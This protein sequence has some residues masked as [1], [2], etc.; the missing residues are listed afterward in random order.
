MIRSIFAEAGKYIPTKVLPALVGLLVIPVFTRIFDPEIY[1]QYGLAVSIISFGS[2]FTSGWLSNANM[3]FWVECK[4]ETARRNHL[5]TLIISTLVFSFLISL[6]IYGIM[7]HVSLLTSSFLIAAVVMLFFTPFI[8]VI[9]SY[10]RIQNKPFR[11][12]VFDQLFNSGKLLLGLLTVLVIFPG[13]GLKSVFWSGSLI[14]L[15]LLLLFLLSPEIRSGITLSAFSF[16]RFRHFF[17]YGFPLV[18]VLVS[19][20]ILT[21]SA[22]FIIPVLRPEAP[23]ELGWLTASQNIVDRTLTLLFQALMMAVLPNIFSAWE[24]TDKQT[25][26]SLITKLIGWFF[27]LFFPLAAGMSLLAEPVMD[28]MTGHQYIGGAVMIPYLALGAFLSNLVHYFTLPCSLHKKTL[29]MTRI[30]IVSAVVNLLLYLVFIPWLGFIGVGVALISTYIFMI[31]YSLY[32][33]R[34]FELIKLPWK[35]IFQTLTASGFMVLAVILL[36]SLSSHVWMIITGSILGGGMVYILILRLLGVWSFD[37]IR[38]IG[39]P[40]ITP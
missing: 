34:K 21:L 15:I 29:I 28:L 32:S 14:A 22:R 9:L 20:W 5:S 27:V 11:Y 37:K 10:Y 17:S 18:L 7:T 35:M 12:T 24:S 13:L 3:R 39:K 40:D 2:I 33:V 23:Y 16:S 26:Q 1:G 6:L 36:K 19:K 31:I 4:T 25:V 38:T 30:T 8:Q